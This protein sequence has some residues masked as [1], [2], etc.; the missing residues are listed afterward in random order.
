ML[1]IGSNNYQIVFIHK[2]FIGSLGLRNINFVGKDT[3][4]CHI[5]PYIN[6]VRFKG[7]ANSKE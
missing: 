5:S 3:Y 2:I 6:N 1:L 4:I 7:N